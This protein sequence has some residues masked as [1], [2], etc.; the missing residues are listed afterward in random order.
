MSYISFINQEGQIERIASDG[1]QRQRLSDDQRF[2]Q[3]PAW[4]PD[5]RSIAAIGRDHEIGHVVVIPYF[6]T[7][8]A[9]KLNC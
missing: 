3:F 4:S 2:Y 6:K 1:T 7:I 5:G 8:G 9:I